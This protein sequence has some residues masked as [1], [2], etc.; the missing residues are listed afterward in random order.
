M[1]DVEGRVGAPPAIERERWRREHD[2][3]DLLL[4]A[5]AEAI[6]NQNIDAARAVG[7]ELCPAMEAHF[8]AEE[9]I[10]FPL[11]EGARLGYGSQIEEA[12]R[13]HEDL[14]GRLLEIRAHLAKGR[15]RGARQS[16]IALLKRFRLHERFEAR[17]LDHLEELPLPRS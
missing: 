4:G 11:I 1:L 3:I 13:L 2:E 8:I 16:L 10:Y 17:L 15:L 6:M 7:R 12:M 9:R 5:L 14:R